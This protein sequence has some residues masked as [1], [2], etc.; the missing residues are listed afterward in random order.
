MKK[1]Q[2]KGMFSR[3]TSGIYILKWVLSWPLNQISIGLHF[4]QFLIDNTAVVRFPTA[5]ELSH[6]F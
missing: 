4:S 1:I 6:L 3:P 5:R 2:A